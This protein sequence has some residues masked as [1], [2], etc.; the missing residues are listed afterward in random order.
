MAKLPQFEEDFPI[1]T[2]QPVSSEAEGLEAISKTMSGISSMAI[3]Q[4]KEIKDEQSAAMYLQTQ[5]HMDSI[6]TNYEIESIKNPD[7]STKLAEKAE[8]EYTSA[9][10]QAIVTKADRS[11]L[12]Y[13][14]TK[15][16]N[17]I[18]LKAARTQFENTRLE[19]QISLMAN[20][21]TTL[22]GLQGAV[23]DEKE[24]N[25]RLKAA[26]D[27]IATAVKSRAIRL[28]QGEMLNK[29]LLHVI[30][31]QQ[32]YHDLE[33]GNTTAREHNQVATTIASP[34]GGHHGLPTDQTT[35]HLSN[36]YNNDITLRGIESSAAQGQ[37]TNPMAW[38]NIIND[39]Q[40]D[41]AS[42]YVQGA[43]SADADLKTGTSFTT[44]QQDLNDLK[45]TASLNNWQR[46]RRDRL[47]NIVGNLNK[48]LFHSVMREDG[49]YQKYELDYNKNMSAVA[50]NPN[51][52]DQQKTDLANYYDNQFAHQVTG[53]AA[54]K[55]LLDE[56]ISPIPY[57]HIQAGQSAFVLDQDP[58]LLK[59]SIGY[60]D[61]GLREYYARAMQTPVQQEV[62]RA[63]ANLVDGTVSD[64][65]LNALILAN[66]KGRDYQALTA[67]QAGVAA[68]SDPVLRY[69]VGSAIGD[70][71]GFIG[72]QVNGATRVDSVIAMTT[73]LAK[74]LA[75]THNDFRADNYVAQ[76]AEIVK[77]A[78]PVSSGARWTKNDKDFPWLESAQ[79]DVVSGYLIDYVKNK[80]GNPVLGEARMSA[81]LDTNPLKV[82][83]KPN[84]DL[85]VMDSQGNL[86]YST[87]Y[88]TNL[89]A[90]A[91][92][93]KSRL[94]Q[95]ESA[96]KK[97]VMEKAAKQM[98]YRSA[99]T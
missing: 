17:D 91:Y 19:G 27:A 65:D 38:A 37:P 56:H 84:G 39:K 81:N 45:S 82:I 59:K 6:S 46:G 4:A 42:H 92:R 75:L 83:G 85:A 43:K 54:A 16:V 2:A 95:E 72:K 73:N 5:S 32:A 24:F 30:K 90:L 3:Q 51:L 67:K 87:P 96:K 61:H 48:G 71:T 98:L 68:V 70:I 15:S 35:V 23:G 79:M 13:L 86:L 26:Q 69:Q 18:K 40:L 52:N 33:P 97:A 66:Q 8:Q 21:P 99:A 29:S 49:Q 11:K 47:N 28:S 55:N 76:A 7:M 74:Y 12:E 63:T 34:T 89:L 57:K 93:E 20:W 9:V 44:L 64:P 78:Y 53:L 77:K 31:A 88:S 10:N 22:Q 58:N 36:N 62:A 25:I 80:M 60:W 50:N 94:E 41:Q 14:A 1:I